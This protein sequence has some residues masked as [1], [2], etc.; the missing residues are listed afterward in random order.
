MLHNIVLVFFLSFCFGFY[1]FISTKN[2]NISKTGGKPFV[3]IKHCRDEN[4]SMDNL[5][6]Q[7]EVK[8]SANLI[9]IPR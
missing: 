9:H 2:T 6:I 4:I 7:P 5:Q 8:P 3:H 1:L